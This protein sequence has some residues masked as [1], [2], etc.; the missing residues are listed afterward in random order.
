MT[1]NNNNFDSEARNKKRYK[2]KYYIR[3]IALSFFSFFL[4][5]LL[6]DI[7]IAWEFVSRLIYPPCLE[8]TPT[9]ELTDYQEH[10]LTT[11][12]G[13]SIR[14]WY[15]PSQNGAAI[16]VFGGLTGA[17]GIRN[18][19]IETL[20]HE[21]YGIVEVD[22]RSCASPV[23]PV[24]L[25]GNEIL[26]GES[27]LEFLLNQIEVDRDRIGAMGFSLGGATA[28]GL[29]AKHSEVK[30]V[31]RDGGFSN[32]SEMLNP[33]GKAPFLIR[34]FRMTVHQIFRIRTGINPSSIS[35]IYDLRNINP[36][37][38]F[39]IYGESEA[40]DGSLQYEHAEEPKELWIVPG[41]AHGANYAVTPKEYE[42]RLVN[43]FSETLLLNIY[44]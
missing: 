15:Y 40:Y 12:D 30:A 8:P 29:A 43:F 3:L 36:T 37:P 24:T 32:L 35:P 20:L 39:L 19:P 5:M 27:A 26:D 22:S 28:I 7:V 9:L 6:I 25:G 31:V 23:S 42:Q 14:I 4:V 11:Q 41:G 13:I 33:T 16:I 34:N 10:F 17:L 21:G 38:V 2:S 1:F 18:F 44:K